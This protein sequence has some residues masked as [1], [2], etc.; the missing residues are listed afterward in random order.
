MILQEKIYVKLL[1]TVPRHKKH[2][3]MFINILYKLFREVRVLE[4]GKKSV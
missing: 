2:Y 1:S 3:T 4:R